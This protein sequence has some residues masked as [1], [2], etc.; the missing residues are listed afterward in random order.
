[1]S[2]KE[3]ELPHDTIKR[4]QKGLETLKKKAEKQKSISSY[5]FLKSVGDLNKNLNSLSSLFQEAAKD[6]KEEEEVT[7]G[8]K[9]KIDALENENR[10]IA[11]GI[12]AIA[13]MIKELE[14][15]L[16]KP[17]APPMFMRGKRPMPSRPMPPRM[18]G[19]MPPKRHILTQPPVLPKRMQ[20]GPMPPRM[21][22]AAMPPPRPAVPKEMPTPKP[23]LPSPPGAMPPGMAPWERPMAPKPPEFPP[24]M[25]EMPIPEG[26]PPLPTTAKKKGFFAKL[27]G[28]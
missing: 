17:R 20:P 10:K 19:P 4:V 3:A 18:P 12:L 11:Q 2:N 26:L 15:K 14:D 7:V 23:V 22:G 6:I 25:P 21:P 27:F 24:G 8:I 9:E 5:T 28:R 1:M 16:E 13:D